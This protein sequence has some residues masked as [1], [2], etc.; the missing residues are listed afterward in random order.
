MSTAD[1]TGRERTFS[2]R[3]LDAMTSPVP[4]LGPGIN[5]LQRARQWDAVRVVPVPTLDAVA[6]DEVEFHRY[7]DGSIVVVEP[8][9]GVAVEACQPVVSMLEELIE[10]PYAALLTRRP[11]GAWGVA[12]SE[13]PIEPIALGELPGVQSISVA[14][15]PD[16]TESALVDDA[17]AGF[18]A[19]DVARALGEV[20][21]VAATRYDAFTATATRIRLQ[22]WELSVDPL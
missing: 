7:A 21:A 20:K 4:W 18:V 3:F 15:L 9:E 2:D 17:E 16:G 8:V 14:V 10:P 19:P 13:E 6:D 12:A 11:D 22:V 1:P 5:G